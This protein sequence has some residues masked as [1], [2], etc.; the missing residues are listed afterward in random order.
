[1]VGGTNVFPYQVL[2]A[3]TRRYNLYGRVQYDLSD[4][5]QVW[6][7]GLYSYFRSQNVTAQI[8]AATGGTG[9]F[10]TISRDNPYLQAAL[11]PAQLAL[12]P[13][14]GSLSIGYLGND[15]GPPLNTVTSRTYSFSGGLKGEFG[16]NWRWDVSTQYGRA[17]SIAESTNTPITANFNNAI[18][19]TT[20]N[21]QIVCASAT[22]RAA[23]CQPIN[24]LGRA[25]YSPAAYAYAFGTAFAAANTTLF[26]TAANLNGEP[27][28]LWAGP[29]S[30]GFG[31]EYRKETFV[32]DVDP[33]SQAGAFLARTPR[34]FPKASQSVKEAYI[35]TIVPLLDV[36]WFG[37]KLDF[38]GAARVTDYS[39]SGRVKTWKV[40][41]VWKPIPD[42]M[43]RGTLS[44][45]IRAPSLPELF[46]A[47]VASVPRPLVIDPRPAFAGQLPYAYDAVTGGN[48]NLRPEIARTASAGV[49]LS[50][51]FLDRLQLSVDY[52]KIRIREAI[53]AT[54]A[55]TIITNC[56]GTGV[57]D[58]SSPFCSLITFANNNPNTGAVLSVVS[59]NANFA[60]FKTKGFDL[61]LNY[62]QPLSDFFT[63]ADGRLV[64][65]VQA[66]HVQEYRSTFDVSLLFPNGVNR[67][68]QTGAIFGGTAG[69]PKW[70]VNS[71]LSYRGGKFQSSLQHRWISRG[72]FNNAFVGPDQAGYS[73]TLVNSI[74][75][76]I[77]PVVGYVN[78]SASFNAG[79]NDQRRELYLTINNLFDKDPPLPAINNNAY[80]DLLGRAYRIG[81]RFSL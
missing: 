60:E 2:R 23:G 17:R 80:Y 26:E 41:L 12:I 81:F 42:I 44:R 38:N 69:L 64:L 14:G 79:T 1:M 25:S 63:D 7:R 72:R 29:V 11:T 49:V 3:D 65:N 30:V 19:A 74:N 31:A 59:N 36:D 47:T 24:I 5:I 48:V 35:E 45:D 52:Y 34:N 57:A 67:A 61:G 55:G 75:D 77:I 4:G 32:T 9:P 20:L 62:V 40:G 51:R 73:P 37:G 58:V 13:A 54:G 53:G 66:T 50:P 33:L 76:N 8:R 71:T 39:V 78:F 68:G 28:S 15:F 22:A 10:L 70:V 18:N 21:G 16:E 46:T 56:I 43:L 6:A 27:F